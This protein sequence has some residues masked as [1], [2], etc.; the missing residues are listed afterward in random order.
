MIVGFIT[1][2]VAA[3]AFEWNMHKK[4]LH[5]HAR[6]KDSFW[7]FHWADHHKHVIKEDYY[8]HDYTRNLFEGWNG[9]SKEAASLFGA[10]V[11]VAP[12]FPIAPGFTAG[13]WF[14]AWNYYQVHKKSHLNPEW[15]YK[16][17]PWH[18]DHH[19]GP[20]QEKNWCV[21]FPLWDYVMGTRVPYKGTEKEAS[22]IAKGRRKV[23]TNHPKVETPTANVEMVK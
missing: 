16:Y 13:L 4:M 15:G 20:D 5:E 6:Q 17:L 7:R 19:M 18:Y 12:L 23:P 14:S 21:T 22:D 1:G 11:A 10:A 9:Q 2:L 8:D 3:N